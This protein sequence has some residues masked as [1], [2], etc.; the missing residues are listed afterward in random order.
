L[1]N[2]PGHAAAIT[3]LTA[4]AFRCWLDYVL[5]AAHI[6]TFITLTA[7]DISAAA[8]IMPLLIL[9]PLRW[10]LPATPPR[11]YAMPLFSPADTPPLMP[12]IFSPCFHYAI[13]ARAD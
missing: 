8:I 1:I 11:H 12:L 6:D 2:A 9:L 7:E 4:P 5:L 3:L 13:T 10:L